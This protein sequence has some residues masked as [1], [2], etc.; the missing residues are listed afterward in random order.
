VTPC[1]YLAAA[2][3]MPSIGS[4]LP[5]TG[6]ALATATEQS[7]DALLFSDAAAT[8]A[9]PAGLL[10]GVTAIPASGTSGLQGIADDLALLA[11]AIA[12]NGINTDDMIVITTPALSTKARVL[13]SPRF[14]NEIIS[15]PSLP[16]GHVV[17]VI[18]SG[19]AEVNDR[20]IDQIEAA[21]A[22]MDRR[23]DEQSRARSA[24][25][26]RRSSGTVTM[27]GY[28]STCPTHF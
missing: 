4:A 10:N 12:S 6:A 1:R 14:T 3:P 22:K 23:T 25:L 7:M 21:L 18:P 24:A 26:S 20:V 16:D 27:I 28:L 17:V 5:G 15:S 8:A 9:A 11:A 2:A 19:V 13:L